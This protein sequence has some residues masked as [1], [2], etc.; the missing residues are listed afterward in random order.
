MNLLVL[1]GPKFLG[2]AVTDSALERGHEL[3]FFNRG[4]TNPELYPEVERLIGDRDGGLAALENRKWDA[5]IDTSGYLPRSVRASAAALASSGRYCFVST[6]S[7]YADFS[8]PADEDSPVAQLGDLSVDEVTNESYGPLKALCET[9]VLEELRRTRARR[10]A[11][12]DRRA[13]RPDRP[14]HV[15]ATSCGAWW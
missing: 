11:R 9:A 2:R 5:V 13:P 12:P 14:V 7:V 1:G 8:V 6:I 4:R 10:P 3:T 15:L